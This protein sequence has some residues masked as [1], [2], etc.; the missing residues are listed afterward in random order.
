MYAYV[1][2]SFSL[3]ASLARRY[4]FHMVNFV[5]YSSLRDIQRRGTV[6]I[7]SSSI[8]SCMLIR[9]VKQPKQKNKKQK[10]MLK[11][12]SQGQLFT[13]RCALVATPP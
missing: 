6:E 4:L 12:A 5:L 3:L 9:S 13:S 2:F 8:D 10:K 1:R 7:L 11:L